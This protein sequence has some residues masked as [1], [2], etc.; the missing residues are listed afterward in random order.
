MTI[1]RI[2]A[3]WAG[4][5]ALLLAMHG[6]YLTL[7]YFW[8]ELGQFVPQALDLYHEGRWIPIHTQ[9]NVHPP[10]VEALLTAEWLL[11][12][13][14]SIAASRILMLAL[15]AF[16]LTGSFLLA[17]RLSRRAPGAPAFAAPLLLLASPLLYTQSMMV[18]LDM[19]AM[20][21]SVWALLLF[22]HGRLSGSVIMATIAV[23][24]KETAVVLP[25]VLGG[26]LLIRERNVRRAAFYL[27]PCAAIGL[28]VALLWRSTGHLLGDAEF[29]QYNTIYSLHP[30]RLTVA[31]LRRLFYL[32]LAE[33][34][35]IGTIAL[36]W[37]WRRTNWL[38]TSEW[39]V[40]G[41]FGLAHMIAVSAFGGAGLERYLCPILPVLF[42]AFGVAWMELEGRWRIFIPGV[43][44]IGSLMSLVWNPPYP[45][46]YENNLAMTDMVAIHKLAA[47]YLGAES[48]IQTV[49]T[50][51]PL[52][53][54]LRRPEFG[55]V[56]KPMHVI[57]LH[58]FRTANLKYAQDQ[59]IDAVVIY[60]RRTV[61]RN[62]NPFRKFLERY[63]DDAPQA[64]AEEIQ[65]ALGMYPKFR[66]EHRGMWVEVY[67]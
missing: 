15:A 16:G 43:A 61:P 48:G 53:D 11:L 55:Y 24:M 59:P 26:W 42:A 56:T 41:A 50:A 3:L 35:W 2:A 9:P 66:W 8:D 12:R 29:G 5:F 63:Y 32:F 30:V 27:I 60:S 37:A 45:S 6:P 19:P 51:W 7:P 10:G 25:L 65:A 39:A 54:A 67:R 13:G 36:I 44:L 58:D 4:A 14:P 28:W 46:A 22:L 34:R 62:F 47:D 38:R 57:E 18:Q 49:A 17:I 52:T 21:F 31:L 64:T 23:L 40:A 1:R 33:F 20:V